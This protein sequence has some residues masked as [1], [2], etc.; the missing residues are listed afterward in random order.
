MEI[1]KHN[2]DFNMYRVFYAV[3]EYESFSRA[4]AE[5]CVSQPA[6]SYTIKRLEEELN[7]KLFTRLN[8]GI[9]LTEEGKRLKIYVENALSSIIAGYKSI[10]ENDEDISGEISIGV[11]SHI[12]TIILPKYIKKFTDKYPNVKIFIYN[13]RSNEMKE[14]LKSKKLDMIMLHYPIFTDTDKYAETKILS[15]ESCFFGIKKYYDS[16]MLSKKGV[17]ICEYPLLLPL[18]GFT[19]SNYLYKAFKKRNMLLTSK[20]SLYTTEMTVSLA[21]AGLGVGWA[22]RESIREELD[23]GTLYEIPIDIDMPNVEIS[24]AHSTKDI[25]KTALKFA[26]FLIEELTIKKTFHHNKL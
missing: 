20:I 13:S 8:K 7:I 2:I 19:T 22:L 6:I 25:N 24:L 9:I 14:M 18:K 26:E 11:H 3:A 1:F 10:T 15:L 5:L 4:A 12:G 21:K 16:F 17:S 23:N